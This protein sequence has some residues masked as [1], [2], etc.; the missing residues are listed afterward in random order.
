[1][2]Q[3]FSPHLNNVSLRSLG[4]GLL[5]MNVWHRLL[6]S[7]LSVWSWW[8]CSKAARDGLRSLLIWWMFSVFWGQRM[9]VLL[10]RSIQG[11]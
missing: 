10:C 1:M 3:T 9:T 8:K 4:L 5:L 11:L 2:I 6:R 7:I